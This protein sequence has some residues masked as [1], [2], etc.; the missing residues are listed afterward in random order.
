MKKI[1]KFPIQ[2]TD[3]QHVSIR[4]NRHYKIIHAGLDPAGTPCIWVE[5]D[6]DGNEITS[7]TV[8]VIGTGN[9]MPPHAHMHI[10][11]FVQGPFV[12]HVYV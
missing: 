6:P 8:Y 5:I 7:H 4:H 3:M 11:S 2:I 9:P 12:W 1:Y 10:G